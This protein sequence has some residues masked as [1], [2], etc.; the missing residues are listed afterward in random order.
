MKIMRLSVSAAVLA[1]AIAAAGCSADQFT[2]LNQTFTAA[3]KG[4]VTLSD[5]ALPAAAIATSLGAVELLKQ[6]SLSNSKALIAGGAGNLSNSGTAGVVAAGGGNLINGSN[7]FAPMFHIAEATGSHDEDVANA[8]LKVKMHVAY[9]TS[10]TSDGTYSS[11]ISSFKGTSQ[12]YTI[13]AQGSFRY[14]PQAGGATV[15]AQMTGNVS[16]KDLKLSIKQLSFATSD[17]LPATA[18]L[19]SFVFEQNDNGKVTGSITAQLKIA[20][21]KISATGTYLDKDGK[22]KPINFDQNNPTGASANAGA[23]STVTS[24][25]STQ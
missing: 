24:N 11:A 15:A 7:N 10:L 6:L 12:G 2:S 20:D 18:E 14:H 4:A 16:Y 17:P 8:Q 21:N 22:T 13:D 23:D 9:N 1:S 3:K 25:T 19:G 5:T